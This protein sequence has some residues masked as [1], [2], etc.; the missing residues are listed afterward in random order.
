M[1]FGSPQRNHSESM[2]VRWSPMHAL[3]AASI[4]RQRFE[5]FGVRL[6][7]D[8]RLLSANRLVERSISI[9]PVDPVSGAAFLD[10]LTTAH[11][12]CLEFYIISTAI[13]EVS[14]LGPDTIS[15]AM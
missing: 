12:D 13:G 6:Q 10:R 11:R 14:S 4:A 7:P 3:N 5:R 8:C 1:R 9:G 2:D 15:T